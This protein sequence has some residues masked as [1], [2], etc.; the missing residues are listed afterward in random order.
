MFVS[1][2]K[3]ASE[4]KKLKDILTSLSHNDPGIGTTCMQDFVDDSALSTLSEFGAQCGNPNEE[5]YQEGFTEDYPNSTPGRLDVD[6]ECAETNTYTKY[7]TWDCSERNT[8]AVETPPRNLMQTT[9][10]LFDLTNLTENN[11][12]NI[13]SWI[14]G[15]R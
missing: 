3:D 2:F 5:K 6:C 10:I 12:S 11:D 8:S 14:L 15:K 1:S 9:D 7:V 4:G 13:N